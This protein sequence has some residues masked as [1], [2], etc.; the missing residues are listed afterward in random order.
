M[1]TGRINQVNTSPKQRIHQRHIQAERTHRLKWPVT[2]WSAIP[3]HLNE[4]VFTHIRFRWPY[5]KP[6]DSHVTSDAETPE[7]A[8]IHTLTLQVTVVLTSASKLKLRKARA[9]ATIHINHAFGNSLSKCARQI[10]ATTAISTYHR[11]DVLHTL[12]ITLPINSMQGHPRRASSSFGKH[13][14]R[15]HRWSLPMQS[16]QY[17]STSI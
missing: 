11:I 3:R 13:M 14:Q 7:W 10:Q 1:T 5:I 2:Y 12:V 6:I 9:I 17:T 4:D 15:L 16:L 8:C